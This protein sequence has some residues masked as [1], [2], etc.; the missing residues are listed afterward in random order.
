[1]DNAR[2]NDDFE[3]SM[4]MLHDTDIEGQ[5]APEGMRKIFLSYAILDLK[6]QQVGFGNSI[7]LFAPHLYPEGFKQFIKVTQ[8]NISKAASERT[9][10]QLKVS[11]LNI[12]LISSSTLGKTI[13]LS[14]NSVNANTGHSSFGNFQT[15]FNLD[16]Y[17]DNNFEKFI[18]DIQTLISRGIK[19]KSNQMCSVQI[20]FFR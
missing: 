7:A 2:L 10:R 4:I 8:E 9:G 17:N 1:M 12:Q 13:F 18:A 14:Y 11:I 15:K 6:T 20:L 5:E 3:G 19:E 16:I